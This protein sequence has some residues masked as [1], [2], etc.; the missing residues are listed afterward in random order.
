[1]TNSY[2][3]ILLIDCFP[4]DDPKVEEFFHQTSHAT[5]YRSVFPAHLNGA[6][7]G[8]FIE[9]HV[10]ERAVG[11][12]LESESEYDQQRRA[13]LVDL[14]YKGLFGTGNWRSS[15]SWSSQDGVSYIISISELRLNINIEINC[16]KSKQVF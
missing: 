10:M 15:Q 11:M 14:L 5:F 4:I 12:L 16:A 1:M 9:E 6:G 3:I 13:P 8:P 7:S 2:F